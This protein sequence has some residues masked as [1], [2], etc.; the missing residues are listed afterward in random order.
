MKGRSY[1]SPDPR[2]LLTNSTDRDSWN[3]I[4]CKTLC[5]V[6]GYEGEPE[7]SANMEHK[8]GKHYCMLICNCDKYF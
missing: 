8:L 3:S 5:H 4:L 7:S 1:S 6:W 2:L